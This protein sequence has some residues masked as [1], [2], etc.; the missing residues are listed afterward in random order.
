MNR[1]VGSVG[2]GAGHSSCVALAHATPVI[3]PRVHTMDVL[4]RVL[5]ARRPWGGRE[6]GGRVCEC[7]FH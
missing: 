3:F 7:S 5:E 6:K 4:L 2:W 1:G